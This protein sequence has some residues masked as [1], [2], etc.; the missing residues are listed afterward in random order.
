M[1]RFLQNPG[2]SSARIDVGQICCV[3]HDVFMIILIKPWRGFCSNFLQLQ[4]QANTICGCFVDRY[5]TV[6]SSPAWHRNA[7]AARARARPAARRGHITESQRLRILDHHGSEMT[8]NAR[9]VWCGKCSSWKWANGTKCYCRARESGKALDGWV[10]LS[11]A[12]RQDLQATL[13]SLEAAKQNA[14]AAPQAVSALEER[15]QQVKDAIYRCDPLHVQISK[16]QTA[17][18]RAEN[19]VK[20]RQRAI[21]AVAGSPH[22][23]ARP[24]VG[25][26]G[27]TREG[28]A[29]QGGGGP[30]VRFDGSSGW[31]W[32]LVGCRL[33]SFGRRRRTCSGVI[34]TVMAVLWWI[35]AT[36]GVAQ[37]AGCNRGFV[38]QVCRDAAV[39][40]QH[41]DAVQ[42]FPGGG[43]VGDSNPDKSAEAECVYRFLWP[44][45]CDAASFTA[46]GTVVAEQE[47]GGRQSRWR[48]TVP[49]SSWLVRTTT[50]C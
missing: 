40:W 9:Q 48:R 14:S 3:V 33:T 28:D 16:I 6:K 21:V 47:A 26:S 32:L 30:R 38:D 45:P 7:R 44:C 27:Q 20:N 31:S 2:T 19:T 39:H 23:S 36:T 49:E 1:E 43:H 34:A 37:V 12:S 50:I 25:A 10:D 15:I 18:G 8:K 13:K 4:P 22:E 35:S 29:T 41:H 24:S 17:I 11:D 46:A 42:C 5:R